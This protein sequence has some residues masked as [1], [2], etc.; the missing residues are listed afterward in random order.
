MTPGIKALEKAGVVF[1]VHE[2]E[3]CGS[4]ELGWG[5]EAAAAM[6]VDPATV[7]KTLVIRLNAADDFAVAVVPVQGLLDLRATARVFGAKKASM[8]EP[9]AAQRLTGYVLGGI[10]PFGQ[11]RRLALVL[12]DA[13]RDC[14]TIH[15]SGGRRGLEIEIAPQALLDVTGGIWGAVGRED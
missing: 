4:G 1:K 15:V 2:Y 5:E 7:F 14:P 9:Q 10:S 13:A 3:A 11:K 6:G 8:C 12:D